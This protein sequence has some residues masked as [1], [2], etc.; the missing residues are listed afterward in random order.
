MKRVCNHALF[1]VWQEWNCCGV[2]QTG[3]LLSQA[4]VRGVVLAVDIVEGCFLLWLDSVRPFR[5]DLEPLS[6]PSIVALRGQHASPHPHWL[7]SMPVF[8]SPEVERQTRGLVLPWAFLSPL[9]NSSALQVLREVLAW[10][11]MGLFTVASVYEGR[12]R[13]RQHS[14]SC[15][16]RNDVH[17]CSLLCQ[18]K[19]RPNCIWPS[20]T[21]GITCTSLWH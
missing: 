9:V 11:W 17:N 2:W 21:Q 20:F 4:N 1:Q 5:V 8:L 12:W 3:V 15:C 18:Y 13:V 10:V 6:T 16:Q 14:K 7:I 19:G